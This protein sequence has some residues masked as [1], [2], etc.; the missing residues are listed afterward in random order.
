MI[1]SRDPLRETED[2]V[3]GGIRIVQ[4]RDKTSLK[5]ELLRIAGRLR[6]ITADA[7]V[8]LIINDHADLAVAVGADGVHLGQDDLPI[9]AVR[10][11]VPE[12]MIIGLS[13]HSR[14][15]A[16]DALRRGADYIGCGPIFAT[17]TKADYPP[18][19]MALLEW[20]MKNIPIPVVAIGG[21]ELENLPQVRQAGARNAAMVRAF[22]EDTAQRVRAV[23]VPINFLVG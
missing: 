18:V 13:T 4:Y 3:R 12:N 15:Q 8:R 23:S 14:E 1:T 6:K 21:I 16:L 17:P 20:A 10:P 2:A 9:E 22:A 19:G 7:G 5:G 11:I